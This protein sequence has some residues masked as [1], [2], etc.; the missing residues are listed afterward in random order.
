M[1]VLI[2]MENQ[3]KEIIHEINVRHREI[4]DYFDK[5]N[6]LYITPKTH[7]DEHFQKLSEVLFK[8]N[9]NLNI[10]DLLSHEQ[11]ELEKNKL[12]FNHYTPSEKDKT[13]DISEFLVF[14]NDFFNQYHPYFG[15]YFEDHEWTFHDKSSTKY[16]LNDDEFIF[17]NS[18]NIYYKHQEENTNYLNNMKRIFK[19]K[20]GDNIKVKINYF[21]DS[22]NELIWTSVVV[23]SI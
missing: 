1:I 14:V 15:K 23:K 17:D 11:I 10:T 20:A 3:I 4:N 8:N 9:I 13:N 19:A 2:I 16:Q 22:D 12:V 18:I 6:N 21:E 5:V 7:N